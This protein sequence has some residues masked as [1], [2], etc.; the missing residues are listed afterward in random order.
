MLLQLRP[1]SSG[2]C[3]QFVAWTLT[4][5]PPLTARMSQKTR[6]PGVPACLRP[7][8]PWVLSS[9]AWTLR[10]LPLNVQGGRPHPAQTCSTKVF[11][12]DED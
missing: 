9:I 12:A 1:T 3:R 8:M 6:Q 10:T 5:M 11:L 7:M 4:T 2:L